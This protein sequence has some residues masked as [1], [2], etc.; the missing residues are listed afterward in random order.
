MFAT[1]KVFALGW[2]RKML[3]KATLLT[4]CSLELVITFYENM[5]YVPDNIFEIDIIIRY[6]SRLLPVDQEVLS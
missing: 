6:S 2:W 4:R 1:E 3:S 5:Q